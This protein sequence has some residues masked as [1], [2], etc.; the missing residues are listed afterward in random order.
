MKSELISKLS[1]DVQNLLTEE[2]KCYRRLIE[3]SE[4]QQYFI[5]YED[6]DAL[7]NVLHQKEDLISKISQLESVIQHIFR[8]FPKLIEW[9]S[10]NGMSESVKRLIDE[11]TAILERLTTL[12]KDS[13]NRLVAKYNEMKKELGNLRW[14]KAIIKTYTPQRTYRPRFIDKNT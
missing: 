2:L 6:I 4:Q 1:F 9:D 10:Q 8:R 13:E 7:M 5:R 14:S 11:I 12:E 3:L